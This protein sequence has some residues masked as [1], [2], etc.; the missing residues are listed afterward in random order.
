MR[1]D[2]FNLEKI[3]KYVQKKRLIVNVHRKTYKAIS[4]L[5]KGLGIVHGNAGVQKRRSTVKSTDQ[6]PAVKRNTGRKTSG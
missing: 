3:V 4:E 5:E 6:N 1:R 2:I